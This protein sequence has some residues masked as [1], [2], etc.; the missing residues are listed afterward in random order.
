M[1]RTA[2]ASAAPLVSSSSSVVNIDLLPT[3]V[4]QARGVSFPRSNSQLISAGKACA[5]TQSMKIQQLSS[6][7]C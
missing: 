7:F 3:H 6:T 2:S 4:I 5:V 1:E